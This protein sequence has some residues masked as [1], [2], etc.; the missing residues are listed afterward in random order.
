MCKYHSTSTFIANNCL[1]TTNTAMPHPLRPPGGGNHRQYA[2]GRNGLPPRLVGPGANPHHRRHFSRRMDVLARMGRRQAWHC[3]LLRFGTERT[4][5]GTFDDIV[6][7]V[8]VDDFMKVSFL[9]DRFCRPAGLRPSGPKRLVPAGL[10]PGPN[11]A[12]TL[13]PARPPR[14]VSNFG[15]AL[16]TC[17]CH[18]VV[19]S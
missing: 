13:G 9:W 6:M 1:T 4:N 16:R 7:N 5:W 19:P 11:F 15:A 10:R 8:G 14:V 18:G 17:N 12:R 2:A 3:V